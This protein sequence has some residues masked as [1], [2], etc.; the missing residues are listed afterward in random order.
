MTTKISKPSTAP[1][2]TETIKLINT[3]NKL[4]AEKGKRAVLIIDLNNEYSKEH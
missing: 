4:A 1:V 3:A 2:T